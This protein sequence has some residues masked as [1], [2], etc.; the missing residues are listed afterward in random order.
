MHPILTSNTRDFGDL[1]LISWALSIYFLNVGLQIHRR[2]TSLPQKN[3]QDQSLD[4]AESLRVDL[5]ECMWVTGVL[6]KHIVIDHNE[7]SRFK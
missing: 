2:G 5:G 1:D 6:Q 7:G 4:V 3:N